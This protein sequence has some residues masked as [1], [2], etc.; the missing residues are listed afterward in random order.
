[1]RQMIGK[2]IDTYYNIRY[3]M[4]NN[5]YH[6]YDKNN[7]KKSKD[8]IIIEGLDNKEKI[9]IVSSNYKSFNGV[10]ADYLKCSAPNNIACAKLQTEYDTQTTKV[11]NLENEYNKQDKIHTDCTNLKTRCGIINTRINE[12]QEFID[13]LNKKMK[14]KQ[15]EHN[16][17]K[18]V[19]P[20]E[21]T[22][23]YLKTNNIDICDNIDYSNKLDN[24]IDLKKTYNSN[25]DSTNKLISNKEEDIFN[26]DKELI[27]SENNIAAYEA[28]REK[29]YLNSKTNY[30]EAKRT[31]KHCWRSCS[32][33]GPWRRCSVN[34]RS[35]QAHNA[36]WQNHYNNLG[37]QWSDKAQVEAEEKKKEEENKK[38][39]ENVGATHK[40]EK[41]RLENNIKTINTNI[42]TNKTNMNTLKNDCSRQMLNGINKI[43][44]D[45]EDKIR[46]K[47]STEVEY[48]DICNSKQISC[49]KEYA[50]FQ[51]IK[52]NYNNEKLAQADLK[53]RHEIC[54]DPLRN[55]CK[56][57]YN[58]YRS[59]N[60]NTQISTSI[61]E[62]YQNYNNNDTAPQV[63]EKI[64][65]NYT[66]VQGDFNKLKINEQEMNIKLNK[67][68]SV[69]ESPI[70]KHDKEIY[71][72]LLLTAFATSLVYVLFVE[73]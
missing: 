8:N 48:K 52:Q 6:T 57:L 11:N 40:E 19:T 45:I 14:G 27:V 43:S 25:K 17:F 42:E 15:T 31:R 9:D 23:D 51:P 59:S 56:D 72:N 65:S 18:E 49:D 5:N 2:K 62:K 21:S 4:Q 37:K 28:N 46:S 69:Y 36:H 3:N 44:S 33:W 61:V 60:K 7:N 63:H 54:V 50:V 26:N 70:D 1:M 10:Y 20:V 34:C 41:L 66:T 29:Y 12:T 22:A 58:E 32:G 68:S 55:D 47:Q 13:G 71:T 64:K 73:M 38:K 24:L 16:S 67:N 53:N 35:V 39:I 30:D